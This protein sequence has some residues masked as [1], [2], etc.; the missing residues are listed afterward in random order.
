MCIAVKK[1]L[2]R[3][4]VNASLSHDQFHRIAIGREIDFRYPFEVEQ[5]VVVAKSTGVMHHVANR[6]FRTVIGDFWEILARAV[7]AAL[8]T[9][10][11]D[12]RKCLE[13]IRVVV[14][15][16]TEQ[17]VRYEELYAKYVAQFP[18]TT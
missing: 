11:I 8:L 9:G 4:E 13:N 15:T 1:P 3:L 2:A 6:D 10:M 18:S 16:P 17:K 5:I 14:F 7:R 12:R